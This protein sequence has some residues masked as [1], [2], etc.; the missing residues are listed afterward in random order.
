M[1]KRILFY[2]SAISI[3]IALFFSSA[4]QAQ[5]ALND[6]PPVYNN[7]FISYYSPDNVAAMADYAKQKQLGGFILWEFRGDMPY[8]SK[9]SLLASLDKNIGSYTVNGSAPIVMGYWTNWSL[10]VNGTGRAIPQPVYPVP[11]SIDPKSQPDKPVIVTNADFTQKLEDM[12]VVTYGFLE[13]QTKEF[14][15]YDSATGNTYTIANKTP[16]KIGT[17]YFNDPWADLQ[18]PGSFANQD[19]LCAENDAICSFSLQNRYKPIPFIQGVKMGNF[20]AFSTLAHSDAKNPLGNLKKVFSVGGYG[21]DNTFEDA[22]NSPDGISKFVTSAAQIINAYNIDGIDLDYENPDMTLQQSEQYLS[23]IKALRTALPGKFISMSILSGPDYLEGKRNGK[24]GFAPGVLAKISGIVDHVNLMTYDF[25][26]AFDYN[27]NGS[28]TTGFITNLYM[29][30]PMPENYKFSVDTSVQAALA[31]QVPANKLSI[32]IPAY[33]RALTGI[34]AGDNAGL[35]Q[36]I[37]AGTAIPKGDMDAASCETA[38]TPLGINSCS[39]SFEYNYIMNNMV[40]HGFTA[41]PR[42]AKGVS[43][44]ITAYAQ[45]WS[46]LKPASYNL[47]ITNSGVAGDTAFNVTVGSYTAPDFFN[48]GTDKTYSPTS[49]SGKTGL[50]V[51]WN[52]SWGPKGQCDNTLDFTSNMHVMIKVHPDNGSGR[53]ITTCAFSKLP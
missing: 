2:F 4:V 50:T 37:T 6:S 27:P 19:K 5:A 38:I 18:A 28:G 16:D 45:Q 34:N 15:Y 29:P 39:G 1:K 25:H 14:T 36:T 13:A 9:D 40:G 31:Q 26:G 42:T 46:P 48:P 53:Y 20:D 10:Y 22:F 17:L 52:T 12:N 44:G 43:N 11:G 41:E 7:V 21:H 32:G 49:I 35:F 33:G 8:N 23:L 30:D 24:F 47:E 51:S 3:I